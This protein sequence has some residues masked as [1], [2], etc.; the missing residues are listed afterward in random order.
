[1][2]DKGS[3][4]SVCSAQFTYQVISGVGVAQVLVGEFL[5]VGLAESS[6]SSRPFLR[7]VL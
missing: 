1:M 3:S 2:G 4:P 6:W 7:L 5:E